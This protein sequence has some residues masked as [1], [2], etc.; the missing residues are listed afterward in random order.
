[1]SESA[2]SEFW[3]LYLSRV[4]FLGPQHRADREVDSPSQADIVLPV[5]RDGS[6]F[7]RHRR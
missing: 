4:W 6:V 5:W 2:W 3:N 7:G 1:M